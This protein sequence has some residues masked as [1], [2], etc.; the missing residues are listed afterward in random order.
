MF[1]HVRQIIENICFAYGA[2]TLQRMSQRM[3][4]YEENLSERWHTSSTLGIR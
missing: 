1:I 4:T 2:V 3:P